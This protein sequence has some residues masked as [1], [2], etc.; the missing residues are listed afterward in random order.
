MLIFSRLMAEYEKDGRA[1]HQKGTI[2]KVVHT[3][4]TESDVPVP[5]GDYDQ[6]Q[7]HRRL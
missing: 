4:Q 7:G 1:F 2:E 3:H 5:R 6:S